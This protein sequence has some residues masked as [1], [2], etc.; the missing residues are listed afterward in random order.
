MPRVFLA[1]MAK[2]ADASDSKSDIERC[3]GSTPTPG[4]KTT[5]SPTHFPRRTL[6][7]T[8]LLHTQGTPLWRHSLSWRIC[9]HHKATTNSAPTTNPLFTTKPNPTTIPPPLTQLTTNPTHHQAKSATDPLGG[10]VVPRSRIFLVERGRGR[11]NLGFNG[12]AKGH[13]FMRAFSGGFVAES[14]GANF[15][16]GARAG[17]GFGRGDF[18]SH[19]IESNGGGALLG[20]RVGGGGAVAGRD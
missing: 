12:G 13:F 14:L 11:W 19:D 3:V 16:R 7:G 5:R 15:G 10:G 1:R 9:R 6:S 20:A 8:A 2:L 17:A 18:G 4:T